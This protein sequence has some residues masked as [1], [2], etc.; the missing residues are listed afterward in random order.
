MGISACSK[1]PIQKMSDIQWSV[2]DCDA[3]DDLCGKLKRS[4]SRRV[5]NG[6]NRRRAG[7]HFNSGQKVDYPVSVLKLREECLGVT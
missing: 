7:S 2:D 6:S 1:P 4:K 3:Q 5:G